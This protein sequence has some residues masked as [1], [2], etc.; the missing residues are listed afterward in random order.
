MLPYGQLFCKNIKLLAESQV[1]LDSLNIVLD[2]ASIDKRISSVWLVDS[3]K[4]IHSCCFSCSIVPE[5]CENL[6][7][8]DRECKFVHRFKCAK[9]LCQ[10]LYKNGV[11]GVV[12]T[13]VL[14][15]KLLFMVR[16]ELF[17][18]LVFFEAK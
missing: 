11:I 2:R 3:S 16:L 9:F 4:H 1:S 8:S 6:S 18:S 14:L 12:D 15:R 17:D 7:L 13:D 10:I 5:D